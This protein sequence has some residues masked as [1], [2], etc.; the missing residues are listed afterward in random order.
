MSQQL[1]PVNGGVIPEVQ[2]TVT[3]DGLKVLSDQYIQAN[4]L[5]SRPTE[6]VPGGRPIYRRLPA[7]SET[8]QINFFNVVNESNVLTTGSRVTPGIDKIGYVFVPYGDSINGPTS[9]EVVASDNLECVL[10]KSGIIVWEYGRTAVLPSIINLRVLDLLR[11]KY[12]VAYQ[13]IYDDSPVEKLYEV[14]DF[15]LTG[16]PLNITGSTDATTG[17]RYPAVNAFLNT[18]TLFWQNKDT[19]YPTYAQ[20]SSSYIQW[21]SELA[22]AYSK[23]T[24]RCPSGTAFTGSATLSYVSNNAQSIVE[25]VTISSDSSGQFFEFKVPAPS[26]QNGWRVTFTSLDMAIQSVT[27]SG[28]LTLEEPQAT[29]SPRA[30]LVIYPAGT[31]PK[32]EVNAKGENVPVTYCLLAQIDVDNA[33]KLSDITDERLIIHRDYVPVA[34]WL[35]KPFDEDLINLY[36]QVSDYSRL[37][38][39][40]PS[41]MKQEY[42]SLTTDQIEVEA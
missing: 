10:I 25:T 38:M 2:T 31:L 5:Q 24:L 15:A 17:W 11:G 13:L 42:A 41:S 26:F 21:E 29:P 14:S 4:N 33:F 1:V 16:Q 37:W 18:S 20:P 7:I 34:D 23:V 39:A 36:E 3:S 32:T 27:V 22:Q 6:W 9:V 19:Y 8:Y 12:D 30:T 28:M 35:T 40:P